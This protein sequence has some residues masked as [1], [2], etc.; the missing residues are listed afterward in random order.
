M[1][2]DP[3][4]RIAVPPAETASP[5]K[6]KPPALGRG[7]GA[8]MGETRREE[9]VVA[10]RGGAGSAPA[11]PTSGLALLSVADIEPH[12]EQP[13]RYFAEEALDEL[14]ASIAQRGVIQPV[15]VRPLRP[16]RYQ[17]VAGERRWRAAQRA[18]LHEIPAIVRDLTEREV[19]AL[20]LIENLQRED[21]N[22]IEEAR[23]Y[24]R[25]A[26][27]ESLTQAEIARMVDKSRSHVANIQ[28]LL[29]LPE[30]VMALVEEGKL[31]MGHARALIGAEGCE[32]LAEAAVA[33]QLSVREVE[34]L[35][36][37][38]TKGDVP[39]GPRKARPERSSADD[40]DIAAVQG[41]LE[42]FLGLPV[43][44][45]ADADPRSGAVTIR[46]RTLD[47]LDL[48]CQRLTG[49]GI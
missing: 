33:K 27:H 35:V 22:P 1:S 47:Q 23:A 9:S 26:E 30:S 20:A 7:L 17:L 24:H 39:A 44:I 3:V 38:Q 11:A 2:D 37:C 40:A 21:L 14:A 41:H 28:R 8:L 12:P 16:G 31:S 36:R 18:H 5:A 19:M 46:Y 13:R 34:K 4:I 32:A 29:L 10:A 48:I 15:I 43:K 42:E 6:R 45:L 25:L 49:G